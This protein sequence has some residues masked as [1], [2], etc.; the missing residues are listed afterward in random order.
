[1]FLFLASFKSYRRKKMIY[2]ESIMA[3]NISSKSQKRASELRD[4]VRL[5]AWDSYKIENSLKGQAA[6]DGYSS[7]TEEWK[8]HEIHGMILPAIEKFITDLGYTAEE[9]MNM[10]SETYQ[11]KAEMNGNTS[12][13][14][15][16]T[17]SYEEIPY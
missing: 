6:F 4:A 13:R 2:M 1:M 9:V 8:E 5:L 14:T 12:K 15:E 3:I 17:S 10:R 11:K 16:K 7:F